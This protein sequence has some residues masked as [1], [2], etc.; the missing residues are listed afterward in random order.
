MSAS[1]MKRIFL[2]NSPV[3]SL[4][5]FFVSKYLLT[6]KYSKSALAGRLIDMGLSPLLSALSTFKYTQK[7]SARDVVVDSL[8][9]VL[10]RADYLIET[11]PHIF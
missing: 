7:Y 10:H 5:S 4:C 8:Q 2:V 9:G 11:L 1:L 6:G 3:P